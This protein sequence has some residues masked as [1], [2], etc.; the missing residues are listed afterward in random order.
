MVLNYINMSNYGQFY[1]SVESIRACAQFFPVAYIGASAGIS[2]TL[3][4]RDD[5]HAVLWHLVNL[6]AMTEGKIS[7]PE[8]HGL[9]SD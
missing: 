4:L 3:L 8:S 2:H 6:E 9:E 7:G 1:G 5:G